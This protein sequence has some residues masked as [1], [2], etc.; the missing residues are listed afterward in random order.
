MRYLA[1]DTETTL[2]PPQGSAK[3]N[4]RHH[5]PDLI[6]TTWAF[7]GA[8]HDMPEPVRLSPGSAIILKAAQAGLL[9]WEDE[10]AHR[11]LFEQDDDVVYCFHNVAFDLAV[12]TKQFPELRPRIETLVEEGRVRDTRVMYLLRHP[13][14]T[15]K[16]ITLAYLSE[17]LLYRVLEKGDVRTSFRRDM[18]L[19]QEQRDYAL[20]D[21]HVTADIA[22]VLAALP[23]GSFRNHWKTPP[24]NKLIACHPGTDM[25]HPDIVYSKAAAWCSWYLVPKGL[26]VDPEVLAKEQDGYER[27]VRGLQGAMVRAGFARIVRKP[28][29]EVFPHVVECP[30]L[31]VSP[32]IGRRWEPY[33]DDPPMM[34]RRWRG[35]LEQVEGRVVKNEGALRTAFQAFADEQDFEAPTSGK[36]SR[37]SLKR[38]DWKDYEGALPDDLKVFLEYQKAYK[39]LTAFLRPLTEARAKEV[40]PSYYIPGAATGRWACRKVNITQVPKKLRKIYRARKGCQFVIADYSTLELY[41]LAH[42]MHCM[43][44]RGRLMESLL[45]GVDVH[46]QTAAL[47]YGKGVENVAADE[48]QAAKVANFGLPGGMG[49]R[50]FWLQSKVMNLG[51]DRKKAYE[52]RNRWFAAYP[53]IREYLNTFEVNPYKQLKPPGMDTTEWLERLGFDPEETWP[54]AFELTR[55]IN[56]GAV[57]TVVLPTGR[58]I[59]DRRYSAAA[60]AFFQGTGADVITEAFN[61]CCVAGLNVVAV[62]HDSITVESKTVWAQGDGRILTKCMEAA[63]RTVCPSVPVPPVA[64]EMSEVWK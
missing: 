41:T 24:P 4:T 40:K 18:E 59:P 51:W 1:L 28:G 47:M 37:V 10:Q 46:T 32:D 63:L 2:I 17:K 30:K 23:L 20:Q 5:V 53:D 3:V 49:V 9:T 19:T 52:I 64:F 58:T 44:I 12:I 15:D 38:D 62:V 57:Y 60:N 61:N 21:A 26:E 25:E 55:R 29:A 27:T 8:K 14:P 16:A 34:R 56:K 22:K 35:E 31:D 39:Y 7:A 6:V 36:Q 13:D 50:R 42:V 48:R 45:S 54:S 11:R 33:Q 43:G